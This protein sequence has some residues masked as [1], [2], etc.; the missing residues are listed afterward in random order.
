MVIQYYKMMLIAAFVCT[1]FYFLFWNKR[2]SIWLTTSS[3]FVMIANAGYYRLAIADSLEMALSANKMIYTGVCF[4]QLV[5]FFC[6]V[7]LCKIRLKRYVVALLLGC[8]MAIYAFIVFESDLFYTNTSINKIDGVTVLTKEYGAVHTIVYMIC[9]TYMFL[10][11]GLVIATLV[12]KKNVSKMALIYIMVI[13]IINVCMDAFGEYMFGIAKPIAASYVVSLV[14]FMIVEGRI[15]LYNLEEIEEAESLRNRKIGYFSISGSNRFIASNEIA[16]VYLDEI[17]QAV[18]DDYLPKTKYTQKIISWV[19]EYRKTGEVVQHELRRDGKVYG[20]VVNRLLKQK[21]IRPCV[22]KIYDNTELV[23]HE[24]DLSEYAKQMEMLKEKAEEANNAKGIFLS[25][26]SHELR[27]PL[28]NIIGLDTMI[29]RESNENEIKQYASDIKNACHGMMAI[30]SDTLDISKIESG[31]MELVE[32]EY[33]LAD[34]IGDEYNLI[35]NR[36]KAKEL[37]LFVDVDE[38]LPSVYFG[39]DVKIRQIITNLLTNAVKYTQAG[40]VTLKVTGERDEDFENL[41]VSVTDTGIGIEE[42]D[43]KKLN[44]RFIR[45]NKEKNKNVEGTGLGI[46][47]VKELLRLLGSKLEI[48]SVYGRGSTFGFTIRQCIV[49]A[50]PIGVIDP[51][52][53]MCDDINDYVAPFTASKANI[54]VVD[55]NTFNRTVFKGLLKG[56]GCNIDEASSGK[57]CLD[58]VSKKKYDLIFMDNMMPEMSGVET[59]ERIKADKCGLNIHTPIVILTANALAGAKEEFLSVGFN[60]FLAKPFSPEKLEEMLKKYLPEKLIKENRQRPN[61]KTK[62]KQKVVDE[63]PQIDDID[64]NIAALH[65]GDSEQIKEAVDNFLEVASSEADYLAEEYEKLSLNI[66]DDE[67][68]ELFRIKVHSMKSSALLVGSVILSGT[69]AMI[70]KAAIEKNFQK[71]NDITPYFL[72]KWREVVYKM[73][74]GF[75]DGE[76]ATEKKKIDVEEVRNLLD[77]LIASSEELDVHRMDDLISKIKMYAF[78]EETMNY[79]RMLSTAVVNI[80]NLKIIEY[81]KKIKEQIEK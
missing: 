74:C 64:W 57:Q 2:N 44:K 32:S 59:F 38:T 22:V 27:T 7:E 75:S 53:D 42:E 76:K 12:K 79:V 14:L 19:E 11:L 52:Q 20:I 39:D 58:T 43:I 45:F 10:G 31:E 8:N 17:A 71:I 18:V 3:I 65:F 37:E 28:N 49:S 16:G 50:E 40:M 63:L 41:S 73:Q 61:K 26:I 81:G 69:A 6:I 34:V 77:K 62:R 35:V 55:D 29:I 78:D 5:V 9:V 36:A 72:E 24:E 60:D 54:L 46:S 21:K 70:E 68:Y 47:I 4:L 66:Q 25:E 80:D 56:I 67:T 33:S 30:I 15:S 48:N 23:K 1:F 51:A 13:D